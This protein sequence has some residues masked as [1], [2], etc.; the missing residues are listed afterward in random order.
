MRSGLR[1]PSNDNKQIGHRDWYRYVIDSGM[2]NPMAVLKNIF[3][4]YSPLYTKT[5]KHAR[6]GSPLLK[7]G[8]GTAVFGMWL[9]S[10]GYQVTQTFAG[11]RKR[12]P[13]TYLATSNA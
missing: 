3:D 6:S 2:E 8:A 13:D 12:C 4:F 9:A 7:V 5:C 11:W 10:A 1:N